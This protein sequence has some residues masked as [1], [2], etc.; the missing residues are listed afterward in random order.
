MAQCI[1]QRKRVYSTEQVRNLDHVDRF[2]RASARWVNHL[3]IGIAFN[4]NRPQSPTAL[5]ALEVIFSTIYVLRPVG[6]ACVWWKARR[7][8]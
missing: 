3:G 4:L 8:G 2:D 1:S 7:A 6:Y 5:F